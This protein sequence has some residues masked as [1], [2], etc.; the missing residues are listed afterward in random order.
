M[1]I[2]LVVGAL[3]VAALWWWQRPAAREG[4]ITVKWR[5]EPVFIKQDQPSKPVE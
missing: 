3:A 4:E 5:G 1:A 2:A